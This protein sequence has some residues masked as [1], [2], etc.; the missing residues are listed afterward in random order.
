MRFIHTS[1][2][3]IGKTVSGFSMLEEQEAALKQIMDYVKER[4]ADAV[5]LSGDLYDRSVPPAAAVTMFDAFLTGLSEMGVTILAIAGN[6]DCG[7]RIG[8]ANRILEKRGLYLEGKLEAPVRFVDIPDQWGFV[9]VHLAPFAKPAE[10]KSR[11]K[12]YSDG[13]SVCGEPGITAGALRFGDTGVC[14]RNG[15]GGSGIVSAILLY[16]SGAYPRLSADR[17]ESGIL[18]RL[19]GKI[20]FFRVQ[21]PEVGAVR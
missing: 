4:Q 8:F 1:D 15:S 13:P 18:Q 7:E 14:G 20:L 11:R 10:V 17:E 9:R 19:A 3:H 2:L 12:G 6:H 16:G 21:S 5:L